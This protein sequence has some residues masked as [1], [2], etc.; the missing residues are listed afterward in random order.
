[1]NTNRRS[2]LKNMAG[3]IS[4]TC[5][6]TGCALLP[7]ADDDL[8]KALFIN[9]E[10]VAE[11]EEAT[12]FNNDKLVVYLPG[13]EWQRLYNPYSLPFNGGKEL[14]EL[15]NNGI[16]QGFR[17]VCSGINHMRYQHEYSVALCFKILNGAGFVT[18]I[19]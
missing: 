16:T 10:R 17:C 11:Y 12:V 13:K 4:A 8:H 15:C 7:K 14:I 19:V 18:E 1:M 9:G 5:V 6:T 2:F 3:L